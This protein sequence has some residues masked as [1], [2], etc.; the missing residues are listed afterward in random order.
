VE[1]EPLG[2]VVAADKGGARAESVAEEGPLIAV[3]TN[4]EIGESG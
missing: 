4:L 3:E 1:G 2:T